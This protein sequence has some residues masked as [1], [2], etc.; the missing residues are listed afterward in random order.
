MAIL[1]IDPVAAAWGFLIQSSIIPQLPSDIDTG[2]ISKSRRERW[3]LIWKKRG[4]Q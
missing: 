4:E 3:T 1:R 2:N